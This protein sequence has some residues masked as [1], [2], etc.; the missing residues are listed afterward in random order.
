MGE[1]MILRTLFF[2][3]AVLLVS[4]L[5]AADCATEVKPTDTY[6]DL[7]SKLKCLNDRISRLEGGSASAVG[8]DPKQSVKVFQPG[9]CLNRSR[10]EA[11]AETIIISRDG[12]EQKPFVLCWNDGS[13]FAKISSID[14][15]Y[16]DLRDTGGRYVESK[17]YTRCQFDQE[18]KIVLRDN[19]EVVFVAERMISADGKNTARISIVNK[20]NS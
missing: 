1:K 18:C 12:G 15:N 6:K 4:P 2:L 3:T 10:Q 16:I 14:E 9:K 11:F 5:Y 19:G 20:P 13:A 8:A 7:T 17:N